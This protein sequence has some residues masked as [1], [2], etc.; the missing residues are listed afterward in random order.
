MSETLQGQLERIVYF[1]RD[2][3]YTVA[4]LNVKGERDLV[5]AV[6]QLSGSS[7]GET[8]K[9]SGAWEIHPKY[10]QQFRAASC[11]VSLPGKIEEIEKYL[12]SGLIKGIGPE[13]AKRLVGQFGA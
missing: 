7:P 10:G 9:L 1:N 13:M 6:G 5:T 2:S 12:S 11:T 8:L 3:L 4:K